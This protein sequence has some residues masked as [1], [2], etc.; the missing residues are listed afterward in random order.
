[1]VWSGTDEQPLVL[2]LQPDQMPLP[3]KFP[4]VEDEMEFALFEVRGG[5]FSKGLIGPG[6]PHLNR[7]GAVGAFGD[8]SF[9]IQIGNRVV[10]HLHRQPFFGM[11]QR[12]AFRDCP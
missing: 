5:G 1:M 12:Q 11:P 2:L 6:I 10:L 3:G 4:A 8:I 9:K 7:S